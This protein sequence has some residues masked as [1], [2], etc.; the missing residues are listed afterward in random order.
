MN[1]FDWTVVEQLSNLYGISGQEMR[2]LSYLNRQLNQEFIGTD[3]LGS[4][5]FQV[6]TKTETGVHMMIATHMDEVGFLV[7]AIEEQGYLRLQSVGNMW[8]H[9]L[10]NHRVR[11]FTKEGRD[12]LGI[13]GSPSVHALSLDKRGQVLS[14][15]QLYVD[16]GVASKEEVLALGIQVGDMVCPDTKMT[17]LANPNFLVGKAFDNRIS[18]A[19]GM[20]LIKNLSDSELKNRVTLAATVQ[21]EVGLRGARTVA[22]KMTPDIA[23]AVDTTLAGDTPLDQN[24]VKLGKG[25]TINVID[26][27]TVTNRGLL[28]YLEELCRKEQI[29]Y[30]LSCFTA[31]GTD[32]GN[33]HKSGRGI[34]TTTL[35][36]PMRYMH[37]HEGIIHK[38]DVLAT[39]RLLQAVAKDLT[40]ETIEL[41]LEQDY[42][43]GIKNV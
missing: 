41:I 39:Y 42:Q 33:I 25:V 28:I 4:G 15:D 30:Q 14:L 21:E 18:V 6:G 10:L 1:Q 7:S 19:V 31:G 24:N 40:Q 27:M 16:L 26:S 32:A 29:P 3:R 38:E 5:L 20:N 2:I 11:I 23:F 34:L 12:Y 17:S 9:V 37:T 13:I 8:P 22:A 43:Y 35:S 36:I